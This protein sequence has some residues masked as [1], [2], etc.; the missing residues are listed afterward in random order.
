LIELMIVVVIIGLLA[1][2]AIVRYRNTKEMAIIA[3]LKSDLRSVAT[4]QAAFSAQNGDFAG[5]A[6][7]SGTPSNATGGAGEILFVPSAGNTVTISWH[8]PTGWN[9]VATSTGT[10]KQCGIYSGTASDSPNAAVTS[11]NLPECW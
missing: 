3:T 10:S 7:R 1:S 2:I 5:S 11:E 8:S 9:A 6:I 4:L